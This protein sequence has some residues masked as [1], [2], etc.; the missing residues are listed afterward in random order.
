MLDEQDRRWRRSI[1]RRIGE[2]ANA[3]SSGSPGQH[4]H[5]GTYSTVG[6]THPPPTHNHDGAYAPPHSHPYSPDNH[7]HAGG[8]SAVT[9]QKVTADQANNT[10]T[11]ANAA[12]MGIVAAANTA[13]EFEY[14]LAIT[15]AALT[16][17]WQFGFTGPAAPTSFIAVCEH[18]SSATAWT[19]STS[20]AITYPAFTLV[21]AAY[22]ITA[23]IAVRIK[24]VLV[25]A[26]AAGTLQLQF[27]SEVATSAITLKRGSTL[28]IA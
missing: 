7:T 22:T 8:S 13:Y 18:Q 25:T 10:V 16:T 4:D 2:L 5:A 9:V 11:M 1:E 27:R 12:N 28:K 15:S 23:P 24:G 17:G 14:L 21:T 6:H 19:V 20:N 26:A 3:G